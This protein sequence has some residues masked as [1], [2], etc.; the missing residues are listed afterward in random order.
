MDKNTCQIL[1]IDDEPFVL[2]SLSFVLNKEGYIIDTAR[3]GKEGLVKIKE[4]RP[5]VVLLDVMMPLKNGFDVCAEV[6]ADPTL[7]ETYIILLTATGQENDIKTGYKCGADD[8]IT[9]PFSI[10]LVLDKIKK[11]GIIT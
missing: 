10:N 8:Y 4:L 2:K 6:K 5:K 7:K 1:I 11:T 9:K 3:D